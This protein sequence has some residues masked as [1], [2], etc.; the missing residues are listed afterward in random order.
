MKISRFIVNPF[1][2]NTYIL[3]NGEGSDAVIVDPGMINNDE[4]Q[5]ID[6]F[7]ASNNLNMKCVLLTHQHAD[8]ILSAQYIAD[9]YKVEIY[10]SI[11]DKVLGEHL[12]EQASA[13]GLRCN[14]APLRVKN[15]LNEDSAVKL[16]GES[17]IVLEVPGHSQGGLSFYL[18]E[19]NVVLVGDSL[20]NQ[21]IGRTDLFG[22]NQNQLIEN[23]N[24]KL[25]VLPDETIVQP[26]HGG[27]TTIGDEKLYNPYIRYAKL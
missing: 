13:F 2:E 15:D 21:S 18:P 19:S 3:W 16:D 14:V 17:I 8:H 10:A 9:K 7:I 5:S 23:I 27:T 25:M 22:G 4:R 24:K 1:S 6:S 12:P 11:K 26:G 20:F